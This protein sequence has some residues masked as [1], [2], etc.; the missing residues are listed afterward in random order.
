MHVYWPQKLYYVA[1]PFLI[2]RSD[3]ERANTCFTP[4]SLNL[5]LGAYAEKKLE[6]FEKHK[7]Q[8]ALLEKA[9]AAL[10]DHMSVERYLLVAARGPREVAADESLFQG[11]VEN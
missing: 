6:A 2:V 9:R 10:E 11:V 8:A 3:E 1:T 4:Y 5:E 7:T